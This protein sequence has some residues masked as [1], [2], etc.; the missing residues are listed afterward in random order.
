[1]DFGVHW[2]DLLFGLAP[3]TFDDTLGIVLS[4]VNF[5]NPLESWRFARAVVNCIDFRPLV[6]SLLAPLISS[7][8][9]DGHFRSSL[10][11][12]LRS[13]RTNQR[14]SFLHCLF[15]LGLVSID[16]IRAIVSDPRF[17]VWFSP[18]CQ[19]LSSVNPDRVAEIIRCDDVGAL[20]CADL[21]G[22]DLIV[23]EFRFEPFE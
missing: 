21:A 11:G 12:L 7:P 14:L 19:C 16:E 13:K 17:F 10:L 20:R 2:R 22:P 1:M 5:S 4:T 18:E 9:T 8:L 3:E 23:P 6:N 15:H